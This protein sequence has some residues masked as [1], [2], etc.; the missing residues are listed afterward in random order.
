MYTLIPT[1][2]FEPE[3]FEQMQIFSPSWNVKPGFADKNE[4]RSDTHQVA[5]KFGKK[6]HDANPI[7]GGGSCLGRM[8]LS[9]HYILIELLTIAGIAMKSA[10]RTSPHWQEF[11][12]QQPSTSNW[13]KENLKSPDYTSWWGHAFVN[14]KGTSWPT[15]R[16]WVSKGS[17]IGSFSTA[18]LAV[19]QWWDGEEL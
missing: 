8:N 6:N 5:A 18:S 19:P 11:P 3:N 1:G 15:E 2:L 9:I 10:I 4:L 13:N 17:F 12:H 14:L 16:I 7:P